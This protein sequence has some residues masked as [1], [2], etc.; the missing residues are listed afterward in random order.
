MV[1]RRNLMGFGSELVVAG[2]EVVAARGE[3]VVREL[4]VGFHGW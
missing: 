2:R 4:V 3:L 1:A